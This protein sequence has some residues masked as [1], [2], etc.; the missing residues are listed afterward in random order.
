MKDKAVSSHKADLASVL[1]NYSQFNKE[2]Y[3]QVPRK[4]TNRSILN[5]MDIFRQLEQV[6]RSASYANS[7]QELLPDLGIACELI[8]VHIRNPRDFTDNVVD[9]VSNYTGFSSETMSK[10]MEHI[11]T[12][13]STV[14][15][16]DSMLNEL[17]EEA[18]FQYGAYCHVIV[19][20]E[21]I[22]ELA[23]MAGTEDYAYHKTELEDRA[24]ENKKGLISDDV[25]GTGLKLKITDNIGYLAVSELK[26]ARRKERAKLSYGL[27][28]I[29]FSRQDY[30]MRITPP[31]TD[32]TTVNYPLL[33]KYPVDSVLPLVEPGDPKNP[34]GYFLLHDE[35][36]RPLSNIQ[37]TD[38]LSALTELRKSGHDKDFISTMKSKFGFT[39]TYSN[40]MSTSDL[41]KKFLDEY[42]AKVEKTLSKALYENEKETTIQ[43]ARIDEVY[44]IMFARAIAGKDTQVVYVDADLVS[45]L[46]YDYNRFGVGVSKLEQTK[47]YSSIR[48]A[49]LFADLYRSIRNSMGLTKINL[50]IDEDDD[51]PA[52]TIFRTMGLIN[53]VRNVNASILGYYHPDEVM[54]ALH[55]SSTVINVEGGNALPGTR[56][57][58]T[59]ESRNLPD[60]DS[61]FEER[62]RKAQ[63]N[64]LGIPP[65]YLDQALQGDFATAIT[66]NNKYFAMRVKGWQ[67]TTTSLSSSFIT[68][69]IRWST[70]LLNE[71]DELIPDK[72]KDDKSLGEFISSLVVHLPEPDTT[73]IEAHAEAYGRMKDLVTAVVE[74]YINEDMLDGILEADEINSAIRAMQTSAI[75]MLMREW[76]SRQNI[77]PEIREMLNSDEENN[78][79]SKIIEHTESIIENFKHVFKSILPE[80]KDASYVLE[81]LRA[82]VDEK[83]SAKRAKDEEEAASEEDPEVGDDTVAEET[84]GDAEGDVDTTVD[85]EPSTDTGDTGSEDDF[86]RG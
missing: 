31:K 34:I 30:R 23:V 62:I 67:S 74:D 18:M 5:N 22:A 6:S 85:D 82:G 83:I 39:G 32:D 9:I 42:T 46:A 45:Y 51:D 25:D 47:M 13:F 14:V 35:N 12:H 70:K 1:A 53:N 21:T 44:S 37:E 19:P 84:E 2:H 61:S 77:L 63:Q 76:A 17:I 80:D 56:V 73:R 65:E 4:Q 11:H 36:A 7:V 64:K 86:F 8:R 16:L 29:Y 48:I 40:D 52:N 28:G 3:V 79:S 27:E 68:K 57:E 60:V 26:R 78:L 71:L 75:N 20:P 55:E 15:D 81:K 33:K 54:R 41:S 69:Y 24:I 49:L 50:T 72:E 58:T 66:A 43:V 38:H 10:L 59:E